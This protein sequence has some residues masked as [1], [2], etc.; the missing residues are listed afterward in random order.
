M[1]TPDPA[2]AYLS[3]R[4]LARAAVVGAMAST[5][6][7]ALPAATF[8]SRSRTHAEIRNISAT[9][10]ASTP[11]SIDELQQTPLG[12]QLEWL[13][14]LINAG[15]DALDPTD[16]EA[17]VTTSFLTVLPPES[18]AGF[19]QQVGDAYGTLE[20]QG[21][22][23]PPTETQAVALV[24]GSNGGQMALA[25]AIEEVAPHLITGANPSPVPTADGTPVEA[26]DENAAGDRMDGLIDIGDRRLY[27]SSRGTDGPTVL[28]ESGLGD[29]GAGWIAIETAVASFA[30]ICSYDRANTF[31]GA[32]DPAPTPRTAEDIV[33]DLHALLREANVPG[34]YVLVGHSYGG[35]TARLFASLYP[36][37]VAGIVFVD[38]SHEDQFD[39]LVPF[40][41]AEQLEF[42]EQV[43]SNNAEGVDLAASSE[44]MRSARSTDPLQPMP[45]VVLTA[46]MPTDP[47]SVPPDWPL[48]EEARI[49]NELHEDLTG[50]VPGG[51]RIVAEESGHYIHQG[52]PDLVV[53]AIRAV[54]MAVRDP[55]TWATP[56]AATPVS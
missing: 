55:G 2:V 47:A 33:A 13:I 19:I 25:I 16:L 49:W 28:F 38:A 29:S 31:A 6:G 43:E 36:D 20:V 15:A 4:T 44:E 7:G 56:P 26:F 17:H 48:E 3:R 21:L 35:L 18:L 11:V 45:L 54:V 42:V 39:R 37:Q 14:T 52:Q 40:L 1:S 24:A 51:R 32:S 8:A 50:L 30:R 34:P 5:V 46:G 41:S 10:V 23:R 12:E 9:A 22:T 53:E 27:L